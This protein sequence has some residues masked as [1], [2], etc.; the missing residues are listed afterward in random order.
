LPKEIFKEPFGLLPPKVRSPSHFIRS[1]NKTLGGQSRGVEEVEEDGG[2][3]I[4]E[5]LGRAPGAEIFHE[6]LIWSNINQIL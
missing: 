1:P 3:L 2:G 4:V 6:T 5:I